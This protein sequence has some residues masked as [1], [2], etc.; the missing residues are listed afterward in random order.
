MTAVRFREMA[1]TALTDI[2]ERGKDAIVVGGSGL[3]LKALTHGFDTAVPPN[4]KL[5]QRLSSLCHEELVARLQQLDQHRA[6]RTDLRNQRRVIRAIEIAEAEAH[7]PIISRQGEGSSGRS[8][9][10]M[11]RDPSTS[12][13]FARDDGVAGASLPVGGI[14]LMR[15]CDDLYA[16]INQRVLAMFRDGVEQEI[17]ALKSIGPTAG[18]AL[19][20]REIQQLRAGEISREECIARIQQKTRRYAKRQ[21][22]WFRHQTSF[23][24]LNLTNLSHQEAVGAIVR[25][26]A[27]G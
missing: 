13:R 26:F 15:D 6:A 9:M 17:A 8:F 19:G 25:A 3:Y 20:F 10:L 7:L 22:T 1:L 12:G 4:A 21:L 18:Q 5:R 11:S 27:Q 24:Q 16:R 23:P 2:A 14:L